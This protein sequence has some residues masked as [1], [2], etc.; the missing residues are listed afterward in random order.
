MCDEH[1]LG[2]EWGIFLTPKMCSHRNQLRAH[3]NYPNSFWG[4]NLQIPY[5]KSQPYPQKDSTIS[6]LYHSGIKILATEPLGDE[7]KQ[8]HLLS[9]FPWMAE[10][11]IS[12][13][14]CCFLY[15]QTHYVEKKMGIKRSCTKLKCLLRFFNVTLSFNDNNTE[16]ELWAFLHWPKLWQHFR[17]MLNF[18]S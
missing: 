3:K 18:S 2:K 10:L 7:I 16:K 4:M 17:L 9:L 14:H 13:A 11:R 8:Q 6:Q 5:T 12:L 15:C 1:R